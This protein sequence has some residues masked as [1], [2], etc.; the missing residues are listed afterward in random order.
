MDSRDA[1]KLEARGGVQI[2]KIARSAFAD[3]HAGVRRNQLSML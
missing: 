1:M 2:N 3:A